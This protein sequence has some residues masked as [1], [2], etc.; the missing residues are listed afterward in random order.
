MIEINFR[1]CC[2][3]CVNVDPYIHE[4]SLLACDGEIREKIV[5]IKCKHERVCKKYIEQE[6][7]KHE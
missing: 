6:D 1:D 2:D 5:I 4:E 7:N 3:N